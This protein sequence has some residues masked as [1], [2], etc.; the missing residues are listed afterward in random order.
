MSRDFLAFFLFHK[1]N[2]SGPLINKYKWF[3]LKIRFREDIRVCSSK[4]LTPRR[5]TLDLKKNSLYKVK[6]RPA[7]IKLIPAKLR[8]VL[9]TSIFGNVIYSLRAISAC[10]ESLISRISLSRIFTKIHF[11][12]FIK[13]PDGF[14]S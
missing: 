1:S 11:Y 10:A 3:L 6:E 7:K 12:L 2:P 5:L 14:D 9:A 8:A 13:G 4:N